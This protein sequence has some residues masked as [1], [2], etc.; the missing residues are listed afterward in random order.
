MMADL[1]FGL[2][3]AADLGIANQLE[4]DARYASRLVSSGSV[5]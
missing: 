3:T 4:R 1:S 2:R 5:K